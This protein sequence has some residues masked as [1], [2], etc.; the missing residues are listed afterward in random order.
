MDFELFKDGIYVVES[1][2]PLARGFVIQ[3]V[4]SNCEFS[5]DSFYGCFSN[6]NNLKTYEVKVVI[7]NEDLSN[8]QVEKSNNGGNYAFATGVITEI[9]EL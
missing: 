3:L 4:N 5:Y 6:D 8:Y 1:S 9:T 7:T 2:K